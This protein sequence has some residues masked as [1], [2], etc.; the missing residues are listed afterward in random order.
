[1]SIMLDYSSKLSRLSECIQQARTDAYAQQR[2]VLQILE[3]L[4]A[5]EPESFCSA[6]E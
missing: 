6:Y 2:S 5:L 4:L 3:E 1:M